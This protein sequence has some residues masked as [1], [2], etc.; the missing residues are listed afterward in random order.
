[1]VTV[2]TVSTSWAIAFIRTNLPQLFG[3]RGMALQLQ[4]CR[5][6]DEVLVPD[7]RPDVLRASLLDRAVS[8]PQ[9]RPGEKEEAGRSC[10]REARIVARQ[11]RPLATTATR[12]WWRRRRSTS[13]NGIASVIGAMKTRAAPS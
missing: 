3:L 1:M 8:T 6:D 10:Q 12:K 5:R 7:G 13:C 2:N 4:P 11:L 9:Q